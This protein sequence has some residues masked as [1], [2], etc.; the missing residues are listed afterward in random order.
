MVL[1]TLHEPRDLYAYD[2]L[3][4]RVPDAQPDAEMVKLARQLIER[5]EGK[6]EPADI[7]DRYEARLREVIEA[8]LKGEGIEPEEPDEPRGDNVIDLM[9][10]LKRSL[11]QGDSGRAAA[12]TPT[13]KKPAR[14]PAKKAK[15]ARCTEARVAPSPATLRASTPDRVRGRLSPRSGR[16]VLQ[17]V[18]RQRREA[19]EPLAGIRRHIRAGGQQLHPIARR[20]RQRQPVVRLLVQDVRAVAGRAGDRHRPHRR[21]VMRRGDAILDRLALGFRQP[22]EAADVEIHPAH[23][24]VPDRAG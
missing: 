15:R 3:F 7:E 9:A 2:K 21:A 1:H 22:A 4:D 17:V 8:K 24:I 13:R 5:Q 6:F 16:G 23:R 14:A 10:A 12:A 18:L 20:Q 11:G 19:V